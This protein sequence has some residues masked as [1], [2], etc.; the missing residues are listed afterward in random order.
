M[1]D[2]DLQRWSPE[3]RRAVIA[4]RPEFFGWSVEA[5]SRYR[6]SLPGEDRAAIVKLLLGSLKAG[7]PVE[8]LIAQDNDGRLPLELQHLLNERLQPLI[9]IGEDAFYLNEYLP[10]GQSVLDF[11]TLRAYDEDDHR[12]QESARAREDPTHVPQPYLGAL[13]GCWARARVGNRLTYLTL[14]MAAAHL[15]DEI[16]AAASDELQRL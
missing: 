12:F 4:V 13:H 6:A 10:E 3:L 11:P 7:A 15:Y 8:E 2:L 16:S 9:G 1:S 14:S 5:Q